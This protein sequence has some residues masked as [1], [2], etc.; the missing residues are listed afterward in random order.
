MIAREA[1]INL[2][3]TWTASGKLTYKYHVA[4]PFATDR[5]SVRVTFSKPTNAKPSPD[6]VAHYTFITEDTSGRVKGF[7]IENEPHLFKLSEIQFHEKM[8][9]QTIQ[10]KLKTRQFLEITE[11]GLFT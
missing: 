8:I 10:L 5:N 7:K 9:D 3:N 6:A 2:L 4:C 11:P 1:A